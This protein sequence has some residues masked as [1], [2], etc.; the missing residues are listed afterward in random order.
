MLNRVEA[1][2]I[3]QAVDFDFH[4]PP[5]LQHQM[6]SGKV[7][8]YLKGG[9]QDVAHFEIVFPAG[10]WFQNQL[11]IPKVVGAQIRSG[12]SLKSSNELHQLFEHYGASFSSRVGNDRS[13][14]SV[15]CLSKHLKELLPALREIINDVQYPDDELVLY[16]KQ[17]IQS[18]KVNL[19][20]SD[21]QANRIID[22]LLFGSKHPYGSCISANDYEVITSKA[23]I[24]FQREH[25]NLSRAQF[26]L[27]GKF[28]DDVFKH[29]DQHFGEL[30][31]E[32]IKKSKEM[33]HQANADKKQ[34]IIKNEESV[35]GAIRIGRHFPKKSHP[36]F[37]PFQ[38]LNVLFGGYFGSRL[39]SNIRE[40]KGYTYG[41]YSWLYN[42]EQAG[43]WMIA[44]DAGRDIAEKA[45]EEI[46][47]EMKRLQNEQVPAGEMQ[48]VKN[49]ILGSIL[50]RLDGPMQA[51]QRWKSYIINGFN[52]ERFHTRSILMKKTSIT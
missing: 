34:R 43:V 25:Y 26:F 36:D 1:P 22:D 2:N 42:I 14:L 30:I 51:I 6:P 21:F 49:Y 52:E 3:A 47:K 32:D 40:D 4:L 18:L 44:A 35:Q 13:S 16:K 38:F 5:L 41:I 45:V 15:K 31:P 19:K 12:T 39:M 17:A 11:G 9:A 48:L 46:F 20:K 10:I 27:S 28:S 50:G 37:L 33:A 8:H 24:D 23:L 29:I 7:L